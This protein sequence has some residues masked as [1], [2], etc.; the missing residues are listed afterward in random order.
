MGLFKKYINLEGDTRIWA[1]I[2]FLVFVSI[3]VVYSATGGLAYTSYGGNTWY[4]FFKHCRF[5]IIGLIFIYFIHK[6]P[7]KYYS[8]LGQLGFIIA[9]P[10]LIYTV[11]FGTSLNDASRW[12]TIGDMPINTFEIGKIAITVF[13]ARQL[14]KIQDN[15]TDFKSVV[16]K[17]FAPLFLVCAIIFLVSFC[18][19][20]R[21]KLM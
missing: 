11:A 2:F 13:L 8:R 4:L 10:I 9:I 1:V 19:L 16:W 3:V 6:I 14:V 7:H 12:I 18:T 17:L 5:L 21:L 15:I 20:K